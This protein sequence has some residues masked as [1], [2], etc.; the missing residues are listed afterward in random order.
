MT[1][2]TCL[3]KLAKKGL[4]IA[5]AESM[6]GG[7]ATYELIQHP[8][9]SEVIKGSIIAYSNDL[10]MKLLSIKEVDILRF[11]VVSKEIANEM[12][13][14]IHDMTKASIGVGITGNAGPTLQT[15][16]TKKEVYISIYKD[17]NFINEHLVFTKE[18]RVEAII[19]TVN[20]IYQTLDQIIS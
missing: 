13:K 1:S 8:G 16:T 15:S 18:N 19:K 4:T 3:E 11:G 20:Q 17:Q 12:A 7:L 6:T 10:K 5:F 9:A 14:Q 2:L